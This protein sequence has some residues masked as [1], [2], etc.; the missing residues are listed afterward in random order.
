MKNNRHHTHQLQRA[1]PV[2]LR[3]AARSPKLATEQTLTATA[4]RVLGEMFC[5]FTTHLNTLRTS[6]DPEVVH[7][8]RVGWRRFK[9]ALRLFKPVLVVGAVPSW[10]GLEVLLACLGELRDL[11]VACVDTLPPLADAYA[12]GDALRIKA[13]QAMVTALR[14]AAQ[15]QRKTTRYALQAP[16][17]GVNLRTATQW[18]E[19]L[20]APNAP[21][22]AEVGIKLSLRRWSRRRI[23]R[24]HRQLQDARHGANSPDSQHRVRIIGKRMRY[25]IEALRD[26]L[27]KRRAKRWHQQAARLQRDLGAARD[28]TQAGVLAAKLEA[29]PRLVEFLR[30]VAVG[31]S[32]LIQ[33]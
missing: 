15:L 29:D 10:Q 33:P 3:K 17:V 22:K 14:D 16:A 30:G 21:S 24:L 8:A 6:D 11:D 9:C 31:R 26:V 23:A 28:A 19:G 18:L 13:W 2:N 27:P 1:V 7:Q 20:S 12:Q 5:Q 4:G 25:G 32:P